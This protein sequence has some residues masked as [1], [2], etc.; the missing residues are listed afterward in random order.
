M[1]G[2]ARNFA[3][4]EPADNSAFDAL[5]EE[6]VEHNLAPQSYQQ[7]SLLISLKRVFLIHHKGLY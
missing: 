2:D 4:I 6:F 5:F 1:P 3:I 7:I